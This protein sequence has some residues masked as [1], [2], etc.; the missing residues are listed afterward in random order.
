MNLYPFTVSKMRVLDSGEFLERYLTDVTNQNF[1]VSID[2]EIK[3]RHNQIVVQWPTYNDALKQIKAKS[4]SEELLNLD[5]DR[6][7]KVTKLRKAFSLAKGTD[8]E[9]EHVAYTK[10]KVVFSDYYGIE[11]LNYPAE[12]LAIKNL[13]GELRT[14]ENLPLSQIL[15]LEK[16]MN[17][18]E[19]ANKNFVIKFDARSSDTISDEVYDVK[20]MR[21]AIFSVYKQLANYAETM[22]NIK[23]TDYYNTYLKTINY[24]REYFANIVAGYPKKKKDD[25]D[26]TK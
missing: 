26:T 6:D 16:Y 13:L 20:K 14:P 7:L 8:V 22:S 19:V 10:L 21:A 25:K 18:L 12:T 5:H 23:N 11:K 24:S 17:L 1:D 15:G 9:E 3:A 2:P 4:E